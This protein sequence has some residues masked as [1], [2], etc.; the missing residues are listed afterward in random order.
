MEI[1]NISEDDKSKVHQLCQRTE[2][3]FNQSIEMLDPDKYHKAR[4]YIQNLSKSISTFFQWWLEK[5]EWIPFTS[6]II[7]NRF[8]Q[9]KNRIKRIGIGGLYESLNFATRPKYKIKQN[10]Y[11]F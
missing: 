3:D 8:S 6:N 2:D 5:N 1:E 7:E 10:L 11:Q 4:A 9:I